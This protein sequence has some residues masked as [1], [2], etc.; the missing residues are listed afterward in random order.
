MLVKDLSKFPC[1]PSGERPNAMRKSLITNTLSVVGAVAMRFFSLLLPC[2][3]EFRWGFAVVQ[4]PEA[5]PLGRAGD[6]V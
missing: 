5:K 6:L 3:R 1:R 2:G 4:V